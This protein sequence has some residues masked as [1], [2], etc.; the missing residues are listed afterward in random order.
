[1]LPWPGKCLAQAA[2]PA[3]LE[4]V[5]S[6]MVDVGYSDYRTGFTPPEGESVRAFI[7]AGAEKRD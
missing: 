2:T 7:P 1:V 5:I 4:E 6:T 3:E